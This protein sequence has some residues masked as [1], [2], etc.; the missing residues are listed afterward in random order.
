MQKTSIPESKTLSLLIVPCFLILATL[1]INRERDIGRGASSLHQF[2]GN[3]TDSEF[4]TQNP[5]IIVYNRIDKAGSSTT[6]YLIRKMSRRN[7]FTV[8]MP[9]PYYDHAKLRE[10]I[11]EL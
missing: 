11:L 9:M 10:S 1:Y 8:H 3:A 2:N 7:N 6:K 4:C 5:Q